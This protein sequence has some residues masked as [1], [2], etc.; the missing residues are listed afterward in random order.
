MFSPEANSI[1]RKCSIAVDFP[2]TG[3]PAE[4]LTA[5]EQVFFLD[6]RVNSEN[7]FCRSNASQITWECRLPGHNTEATDLTGS[8]IGEV[9]SVN[10]F[11]CFLIN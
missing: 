9:G 2:K 7:L 4:Q 11:F 5:F 3:V 1:A 10:D 6:L 8:C